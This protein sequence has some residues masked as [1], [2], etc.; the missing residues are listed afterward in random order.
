MFKK[1]IRLPVLEI[2]LLAASGLL[3]HLRVH[4]PGKAPLNYVPFFISLFSVFVLPFLFSS[5][6]TV[7]AAYVIN[8]VI[9]AIGVVGMTYYSIAYWDPNLPVNMQ[10]ILVQTTLADILIV[11]GRLTLG[12]MILRQFEPAGALPSRD[13]ASSD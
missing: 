12:H 11:G 1:E 7:F 9:V 3:L 13:P 4:P 5:A 6:K 10:N 8:I 2:F